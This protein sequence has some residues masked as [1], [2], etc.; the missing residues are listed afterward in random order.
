MQ[1]NL[2]EEIQTAT[3]ADRLKSAQFIDSVFQT[4]VYGWMS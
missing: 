2:T 3:K 4:N 1:S